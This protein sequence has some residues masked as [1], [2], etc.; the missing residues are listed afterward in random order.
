MELVYTGLVNAVNHENVVRSIKLTGE[1]IIP[2][3]HTDAT[4]VG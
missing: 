2:A 3:L 4:T 1:T